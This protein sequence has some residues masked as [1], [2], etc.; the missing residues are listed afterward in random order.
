MDNE[1]KMLDFIVS[2]SQHGFSSLPKATEDSPKHLK[3][4]GKL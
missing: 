4:Q 1:T 2:D 3:L